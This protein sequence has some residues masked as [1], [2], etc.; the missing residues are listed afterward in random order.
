MPARMKRPNGAGR[1]NM[2]KTDEYKRRRQAIEA[3]STQLRKQALFDEPHAG[4]RGSHVP[5]TFGLVYESR[6]KRFCLFETEKKH[7]AAV[8]AARFA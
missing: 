8:N 7:L 1:H 5:A 4:A 3:K 6:D 2:E